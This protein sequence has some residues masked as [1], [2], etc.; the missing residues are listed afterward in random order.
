M[1]INTIFNLNYLIKK[2]KTYII[3]SIEVNLWSDFHLLQHSYL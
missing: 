3:K 1:L 2:S